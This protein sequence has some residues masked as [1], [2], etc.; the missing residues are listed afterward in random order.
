MEL[1]TYFRSSAAFLRRP[2]QRL[3]ETQ[4]EVD[5]RR[6]AAEDEPGGAGDRDDRQARRRRSV[7]SPVLSLPAEGRGLGSLAR[8]AKMK[9]D[10]RA[11]VCRVWT[12]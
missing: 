11:C 6:G 7:R 2:L 12:V 1:Y 8:N 10:G 9:S 5:A 3:Q 4:D